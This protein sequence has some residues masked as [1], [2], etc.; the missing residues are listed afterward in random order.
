MAESLSIRF[1]GDKKKGVSLVGFARQSLDSMKNIM[2]LGGLN[3]YTMQKRF[4]DGTEIILTSNYGINI[5]SIYV[6]IVLEEVKDEKKIS[7]VTVKDNVVAVLDASMALFKLYL[8]KVTQE[9]LELISSCEI[10]AGIYFADV[11]L[12][13]VIWDYKL[14]CYQVFVGL[15]GLPDGKYCYRYAVSE[16]GELLNAIATSLNGLPSVSSNIEVIITSVAADP[17][18][19]YFPQASGFT[20]MDSDF[21][22]TQIDEVYDVYQV[23]GYPTYSA[24]PMDYTTQTLICLVDQSV[25]V[26]IHGWINGA[27]PYNVEWRMFLEDYKTQE[28]QEYLISSTPYVHYIDSVSVYNTGVQVGDH[29]W[30]VFGTCSQDY[31]YYANSLGYRRTINI[32]SVPV[33]NLLDYTTIATLEDDVIGE[34]IFTHWTDMGE[35]VWQSTETTYAAPT[36]RQYIGCMAY[37][38]ESKVVLVSRLQ[39][40]NTGLEDFSDNAGSPQ[41]VTY[42]TTPTG[43]MTRYIDAYNSDGDFLYSK[44]I[45]QFVTP[46]LWQ[47][48]LN[49]GYALLSDYEH[50]DKAT[51]DTYARSLSIGVSRKSKTYTGV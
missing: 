36:N 5:I 50:I 34:G 21:N 2:E 17:Y 6:P 31:H 47:Y 1:T 44:Q 43:L 28:V 35:G 46:C 20:I 48:D 16:T 42:P 38:E 7:T 8:Y 30:Y 12:T 24:P 15:T 33:D 18:N 3:T 26:Y 40:D 10:S 32:R 14:D 49:L 27:S 37:H 22:I 9:E 11:K 39:W 4:E 13:Q 25:M 23:S 41:V 29:I 45:D 51:W 19:Y